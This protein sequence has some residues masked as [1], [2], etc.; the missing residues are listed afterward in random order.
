MQKK[1]KKMESNELDLNLSLSGIIYNGPCLEEH[2]V[3]EIKQLYLCLF[4]KVRRQENTLL[5]GKTLGSLDLIAKDN[6]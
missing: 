1:K 4:A 3:S 6:G 5:P 2:M